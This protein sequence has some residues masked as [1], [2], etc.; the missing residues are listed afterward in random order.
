MGG[1]RAVLFALAVAS[2]STLVVLACTSDEYQRPDNSCQPLTTCDRDE[3][4]SV[5]PTLTSDRVC[6][7]IRNCTGLFLVVES[8]ATSDRVCSKV[9]KGSAQA[10]F[11][12]AHEGAD[13]CLLRDPSPLVWLILPP[14]R[15]P[16]PGATGRMARGTTIGPSPTL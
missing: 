4:E 1:L 3:Y 16:M 11:F 9:G 2:C 15:I 6:N 13:A 14:R 7:P 10:R 8:T 5:P 12:G